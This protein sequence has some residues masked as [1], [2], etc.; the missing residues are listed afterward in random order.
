MRNNENLFDK[1]TNKI[2]QIQSKFVLVLLKCWWLLFHY[3][4]IVWS[5]QYVFF[6]VYNFVKNPY[7]FYD[8]YLYNK[9]EVSKDASIRALKL[10]VI[11]D[12]FLMD[13]K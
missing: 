7:E 13:I 2:T 11:F 5:L 9:E 10:W 4:L 3:N 1:I 12:Y 8:V 6:Y